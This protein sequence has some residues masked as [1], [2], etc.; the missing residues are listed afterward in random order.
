MWDVVWTDPERKSRKEHRDR[1]REKSSKQPRSNTTS[2]F[3]A[4]RS[5]SSRSSTSTSTTSFNGNFLTVSPGCRRAGRHFVASP[6]PTQSSFPASPTS[7]TSTALETENDSVSIFSACSES[8]PTISTY[9][10]SIH[11]HSKIPNYSIHCSRSIISVSKQG[12]LPNPRRIFSILKPGIEVQINSSEIYDDSHLVPPMSP[13][14][15]SQTIERVALEPHHLVQTLSEDSY[16]TRSTEVTLTTRSS[17]DMSMAM[18]SE[19]TITADTDKKGSNRPLT[20]NS[21]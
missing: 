7:L 18:S 2:A 13:S 10:P 8:T 17:T 15:P 21:Q 5:I 11:E 3:G 6:S 19:V 1:K 14:W 16:I 12:S 4:A 9:G 20:P